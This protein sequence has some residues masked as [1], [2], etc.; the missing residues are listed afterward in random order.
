MRAE[1]LLDAPHFLLLLRVLVTG[2]FG[3]LGRATVDELLGAGKDVVAFDLPTRRASR[4]AARLRREH[5]HGRFSAV[6]GDI[7][8]AGSLL[9]ICRDVDAI[10]HNAAILPPAS[11][12]QPDLARAVNVEGLR[13]L[14]EAA[15]RSPRRPRFVF[16][17]S[18]T[19][20]GPRLTETPPVR[21][22]DPVH[23]TDGYTHHKVEGEAMIRDSALPWVILR[24]GVSP[25]PAATSASLDVIRMLFEQHPDNRIEYVHPTGVARAM[26]SA[27]TR[28]EG[29][30][31]GKVLLVGGGYGCR[32]TF[33]DLVQALFDGLGLGPVP[34][35]AF[36][37]A[38]YYTDWMDTEEAERLL[39][40][41]GGQWRD[42]VQ[43][44]RAELAPARCAISP[45]RPLV[46]Y[47]ALK[48][49]RPWQ[50]RR[51]S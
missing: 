37:T 19:T 49:S 9:K 44:L 41:Q 22:T 6:F 31:A 29:A 2:A 11:E 4:A 36:G 47:G 48:L 39:Q 46:R 38:S 27:A 33:F 1:Q 51:A 35:E 5:G 50:S 32:I 24:V 16:P 8:D 25:D 34:R 15:K 3:N 18:V 12:A 20:F 28:P 17:S 43:E 7:R 30:V 13:R 23:P 26:V 10:I 40:F 14:L 42:Y 45:V 21:A